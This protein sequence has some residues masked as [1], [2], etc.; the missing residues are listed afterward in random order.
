[1][2]KAFFQE[3]VQERWKTAFHIRVVKISFFLEDG[4]MKIVEPSVDNSGLEQGVL[5]RRQRIPI[6]DP[7]K[8]RYYDILDLNVGREPEIYG[9]VYK[10]VDCDRFTRQFLN[11]M[12]IPVPDPIDIPKDPH[13]EIRKDEAFP[14]KPNRI[15]DS[16]GS[17]LKYDRKVLRFYGYWD[18]T[19][20]PHGIVHDLELHYYLSDNTMEIKENIPPN[21][22]RDSGPM[23]VKR[24]KIPKFYSGLQPIGADD[25][26]TVLN[27]LG[28]SVRQGYYMVDSLDTGKISTDYYRDNE[29]GIGAEI[30][31]FGRRIVITDMDA[32]TKE[33]YRTKYGLSDFA[34]LTRP[35]KGDEVYQTIERYIPPY[36]GFGSYEDSLGNCFTVMPKPPKADFVKFLYHDRQGFNSHVLRFRAKMISKLPEYEERLFI[37]RVYLM[38]DTISVFELAKRNSG[39]QKSLFQKRM[40][41]MLPGQ[42]I[43]TSKKPEYYKSHDF[44]IGARL[45]LYDFHFEITSADVYALRYME[46]H[47]DKFPKAN[48]KLIMEK[49]RESLQPVYKEFVQ[50]Y[51]PAKGAAEGGIRILEYERLK[52]ALRRYMGDRI[53]EHEM[54]TI[55]R[56]YS[57]CEKIEHRSRE[58]VRCLFHTELNR[59]LWN[60]L[61]RL[62]EDLRHWD[63]DKTGFLPR[64]SVYTI[65]RGC[66]I[67]VDV[68]LLNSML[69]HLRKAEDGRIDYEDLLRFMNVKIDPMPP[70]EPVNVKMELWWASEREP[71]CGGINWCE[72]IK[73]LDIRAEENAA[74]NNGSTELALAD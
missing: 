38:D 60:D 55:A 23:L 16:L 46:L 6:P 44:Y 67:P 43:F 36:N 66:R 8:Y 32:F 50:L 25:R 61:D 1:M 26:F 33:Y 17:F 41:I 64:E 5:V 69:D 58:Y 40:P 62:E 63:E 51:A 42:D 13:H 20:S 22:G 56:Y 21:A 73:D 53:T 27:V 30:N 35:R 48:K 45:S 47:C 3:T 52:E 37:I 10:I 29:L 19:E 74:E 11:R 70:T 9:R 34:P 71:D 18:D 31:A 54:I 24:M 57:S 59:F 28:E 65:L 2:F 4:T 15:V 12:G 39:F 14:K 49:L 7:V 68:E 72:F